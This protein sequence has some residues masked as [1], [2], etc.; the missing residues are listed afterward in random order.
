VG[1]SFYSVLEDG[2]R[3]GVIRVHADGMVDHLIDGDRAVKG[4]TAS[5]DGS[6]LAFVASTPVDPG[7]VY[8]WDDGTERCLTTLNEV[9]RSEVQ[10]VEPE[11]FRVV[12]GGTEIDAW[13]LLPPGDET[14]PLLLNIHGGPASQY[15]FGFFDEFQVYAGA[16]YGV[17]AI[18][19]RGSS[20]YGTAHMQAVVGRWHEDEPPDIRDLRVAVDVAAASHPRLDTSRMGVMGGSYGGLITVRLLSLDARY[21]S[22]VAERGLYSWVSFAGTSDIGP[23][24]DRLYLAAQLPEGADVMWQSSSLAHAHRIETPTLILHSE[25]DFRTPV[26]QAEQLYVLLRRIGVDTELVRF[27]SGEGHELSRSGKPRHRRERFEIIL[28]WHGRYLSPS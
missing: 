21:R 3:I 20:G 13:A 27:P 4:V 12:S 23:W 6:R 19:P 24:F 2:G 9:F 10:L 22:A 28:D 7:E 11:H 26:E 18:N 25:S 1:D 16:G 5:A 14:V 17:V 8:L 15:G